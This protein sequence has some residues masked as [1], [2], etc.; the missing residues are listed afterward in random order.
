MAAIRTQAKL[1]GK[2]Q[3]FIYQF[4]NVVTIHKDSYG[5]HSSHLTRMNNA[6]VDEMNAV[7]ELPKYI[8]LI[9][10]ADIIHLAGYFDYGVKKILLNA[11]TWL[12][13]NISANLETRKEDIKA[14][15]PGAL[16]SFDEP[17]IIWV[18]AIARP[19]NSSKKEVYS[20]IAKF[21]ECI[22]DLVA[23]NHF[24]YG[25]KIEMVNELNHFDLGGR[26]AASGKEMLWL[27]IDRK[28]RRFDNTG[29]FAQHKETSPAADHHLT[30]K[31]YHQGDGQD[32]KKSNSVHSNHRKE[33]HSTTEYK[34][35]ARRPSYTH[36]H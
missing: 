10:D 7:V 6:V 21:N 23:R 2:D 16:F 17:K 5:N 14:K 11:I 13:S 18:E 35:G 4:F 1:N 25:M 9:L 12:Y 29:A 33:T 30:Y 26:L 31:L 3:P 15:R 32:H 24:N 8:V 28:L 22:N 36:S 20:L 27:E 34:H 19:P